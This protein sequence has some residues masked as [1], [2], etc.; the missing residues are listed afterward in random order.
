MCDGYGKKLQE[1]LWFLVFQVDED[2]ND[3]VD[4]KKICLSPSTEA[5][6]SA[7]DTLKDF[8]DDESSPTECLN[9]NINGNDEHS[10]VFVPVLREIYSARFY[11]NAIMKKYMV[12]RLFTMYHRTFELQLSRRKRCI[13]DV[14][15]NVTGSSR[16]SRNF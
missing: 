10:D 4:G 6:M 8:L 11:L 16:C 1:T 5:V 9:L 3:E 7:A 13:R 2:L 12:K 14:L 15:E